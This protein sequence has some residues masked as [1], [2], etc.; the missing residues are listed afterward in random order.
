MFGNYLALIP[1]IKEALV[2]NTLSHESLSTILR[3]DVL[4]DFGEK[5][6][7][8]GDF[9]DFGKI[10][11]PFKKLGNVDSSGMFSLDEMIVFS[12]Y[13]IKRD[14]YKNVLDIGGNLGIHS[15]LLAKLGANVTTFEPDPV[16]S[17]ALCEN[18]RLNNLKNVIVTQKAVSSVNGNAS[19]CRVC[20]N[21]A[22]SHI[23]GAKDNPYGKL[24]HFEVEL[25][26]FSELLS[27]I[28]YI[29]IDAEGSESKILTSVD[30]ELLT[31]IDCFVEVGSQRNAK[32]I[33]D[34]FQH[35]CIHMFSQKAGWHRVSELSQ[36]PTHHSEGLLFISG[37]KSMTWSN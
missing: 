16:T 4:Q 9:G 21:M 26:S 20:D 27:G 7:G 12:Y 6:C 33:F 11:F 37:D 1:N 36:V 15:I 18:L 13:I 34:H 30:P 5:S 29:K 2:R 35:S 3:Q 19:F 10:I 32:L 31:S 22:A 25:V 8:E 23:V 24:E 14:K 17:E 28:D